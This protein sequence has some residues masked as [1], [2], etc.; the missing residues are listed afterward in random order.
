MQ[1][2]FGILIIDYIPKNWLVESKSF[3]IYIQ[4]YRNY[5]IFH[6]EAVMKIG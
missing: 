5:G 2:D 4:S 3:K 6:E 1:P